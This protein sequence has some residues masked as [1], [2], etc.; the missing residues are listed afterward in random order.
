MVTEGIVKKDHFARLYRGDEL[1]FEG[2]IASL[3]KVKEDVKEMAKGH[4]CGLLLVKFKDYQIG[5][6]VKTFDVTYIQQEL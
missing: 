3:K 2:N 4:E 1:L 6:I 5:D